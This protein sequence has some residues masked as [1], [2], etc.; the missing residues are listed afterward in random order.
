EAALNATEDYWQAWTSTLTLPVRYTDLVLRSLITLKACV[1]KPSGAVVAAPTFGLPESPGGERNWDYRFCWV[2]DASLS[3]LALLR[4]GANEEAER[5]FNWLLDAV[6]GAPGQLQIMYGVRGERRLTEVELPWLS[7]YEGARPVRIGNA[8]YEQF[9]LD[10]VGEF[11]T[12]LYT[13]A[14]HFGEVSP[15]VP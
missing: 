12:L 2:R 4:A 11:A 14:K 15:K 6:G 5:F 8:A 1:F 13:G 3:L 10:I 9:Q 7:G